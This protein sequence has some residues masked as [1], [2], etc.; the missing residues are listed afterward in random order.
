MPPAEFLLL[1][2]A[3]SDKAL[4]I[5]IVET[6]DDYRRVDEILGGVPADEAAGR[7]TSVARYEVAV[8][9]SPS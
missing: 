3:E 8:R 4:A 5:V 1:H 9:A 6:E 2:D 7:R